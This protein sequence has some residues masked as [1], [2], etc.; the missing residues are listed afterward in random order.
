MNDRT[1][2][3]IKKAILSTLYNQFSKSE[4]D[5][6]EGQVKIADHDDNAIYLGLYPIDTETGEIKT[7]PSHV[8]TIEVSISNEEVA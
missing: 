1:N 6:E 7:K 4:F 2:D 3:K 8:W 5:L